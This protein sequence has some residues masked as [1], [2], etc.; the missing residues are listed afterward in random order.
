[1]ELGRPSAAVNVLNKD[2]LFPLLELQ[3]PLP[4][5]SSGAATLSIEH[6]PEVSRLYGCRSGLRCR[7]IVDPCKRAT[8]TENRVFTIGQGEG[9]WT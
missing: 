5:N 6:G 1:M 4:F 8:N 7:P 3:N 2:P 9:R